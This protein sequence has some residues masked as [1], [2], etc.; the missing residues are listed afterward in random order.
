MGQDR[1]DRSMGIP[2]LLVAQPLT[3]AVFTLIAGRLSESIFFF[4]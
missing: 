2:A 1:I 3:Q 4:T